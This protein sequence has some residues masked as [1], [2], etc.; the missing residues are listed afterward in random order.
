MASEIPALFS[1]VFSKSLTADLFEKF[2]I[3]KVSTY[4]VL[5]TIVLYAMLSSI[6]LS[7]T[8]FTDPSVMY[9]EIVCVSRLKLSPLV[10][11]FVVGLVDVMIDA[12]FDVMGIKL[13]W[14]TWHES[15][16]NIYDRTFFVPW[17]KCV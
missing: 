12:P 8:S 13:M 15:D 14:W 4:M 1:K 2:V 3:R 17:T 9:T 7:S 16:P 6:L 10:E 5:Q 11:P